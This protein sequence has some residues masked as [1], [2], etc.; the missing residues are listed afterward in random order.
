MGTPGL[1]RRLAAM[2]YEAVLLFAVA[3]FAGWLFY[4]ASGGR[5]ATEGWLRHALQ[6]FI[7][8]AVGALLPVIIL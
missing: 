1:L 3:F 6:L 8:A 2:L 4:A 5:D 7:L